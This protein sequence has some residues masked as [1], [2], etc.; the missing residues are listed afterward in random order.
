VEPFVKRIIGMW[1]PVYQRG[2]CCLNLKM[3]NIKEN[4]GMMAICDL[5]EQ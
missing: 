5:K 2:N 4:V 3:K 1:K